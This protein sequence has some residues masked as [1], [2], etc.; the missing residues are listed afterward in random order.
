MNVMATIEVRANQLTGDVP[1]LKE[2]SHLVIVVTDDAGN[3]T[4]FRGGP[5]VNQEGRPGVSPSNPWGNVVTRSGTFEQGGQDWKPDAVV[6]HRE[7]IPQSEVQGVI[8]QFRGQLNA[9]DRA[10]VPYA[11]VPDGRGNNANSNSVAQTLMQNVRGRNLNISNSPTE[12][13]NGVTAPGVNVRIVDPAGRRIPP[14]TDR[15]DASPTP[16]N[17][18]DYAYQS[19][20]RTLADA[21]IN[22]QNNPN[23]DGLM[24][25]SL[26]EQGHG[27]NSIA[28][29][30]INNS[31]TLDQINREQG[32]T[33][34]TQA[35]QRSFAYANSLDN[36]ANRQQSP[37][38][39]EQLAL[40]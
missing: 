20:A 35:L 31:E 2:P 12:F 38:Q 5:G 3:R 18:S 13:G 17:E 14:R 16:T 9:I 4:Y 15:S 7:T 27:A 24:V 19:T 40:G 36:R 1:G 11:P 37:L 23:F 25:Y 34:A 8:A 10:G 29:M 32:S 30:L 28:R 6:I 33:E 21:G 26:S 22:P 39:A